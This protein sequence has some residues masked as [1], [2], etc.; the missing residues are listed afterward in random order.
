VRANVCHSTTGIID[1]LDALN[2][3]ALHADSEGGLIMEINWILAMDNLML[4]I[5]VIHTPVVY[6]L[7]NPVPRRVWQISHAGNQPI[8]G[9][10]QTLYRENQ[11]F[12]G[13]HGK[14][15]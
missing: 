3:Y 13:L 10:D 1:L 5:E 15:F 12:N 2:R 8:G 11:P 6:T 7:T 14:S 9:M 4:L